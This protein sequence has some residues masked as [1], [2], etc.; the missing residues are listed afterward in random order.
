MTNSSPRYARDIV[1]AAALALLLAGCAAKPEKELELGRNAFSTANYKAASGHFAKAIEGGL[2]NVDALV[3]FARSE[4]AL[5]RIDSAQSALQKAAVS[6]GGDVDIIEL[7]A[8]LAFYKKDFAAARE[9]YSRLAYDSSLDAAVRS[10]GFAGLGVIEFMLIGLNSTEHWHRHASRVH[11]LRA[12]A[13]DRRNASARY[14]LGRLYRDSFNYLE[15]AR[16]QFEYYVHLESAADARVRKVQREVLPAL[17]EEI[18]RNLA[19]VSSSSRSNPA[20]CA[21]HLK[22]ADIAYSSKKYE[23]AAANYSK[24]LKSDPFNYQARLGLARS[25]ANY[26]NVKKMREAALD[27]YLLACKIRPTATTVLLESA[28]LA[29]RLGKYATACELYSRALASNP[30]NDRAAQG[31][32]NMFLRTGDE[33]TA[34][35]YSDYRK[36]LSSNK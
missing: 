17:K 7:S 19:A 21:A 26:G 3:M 30:S 22:T 28:E 25:Q 29:N 6:N 10:T 15:H 5:G 1:F 16:D 13:F 24:A 14:H 32:I 2:A 36:S 20:E 23:S 12:L 8:Q 33:K 11:F 31:L 27:S 18:A 4:F 9:G 34:G 35:V